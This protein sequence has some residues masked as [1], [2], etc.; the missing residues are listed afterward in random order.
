MCVPGHAQNTQNNKFAISFQYL[1]KEV[2]DEVDFLHAYKHERLLQIDT[3][4]LMGSSSIP[5]VSKMA[6]LQC[7][8]KISKK[9]LDMKLIF[10]M[11]MNIKILYKLISTLRKSM[12]PTS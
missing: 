10:C 4:I 7:L 2:S 6:S 1:K 12:F 5:K 11:Q 3:M 8:C 9:K